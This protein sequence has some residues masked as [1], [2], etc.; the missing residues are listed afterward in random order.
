[1]LAGLA[2]IGRDT[3]QA[4]RMMLR[5]PTLAAV[6]ILS[7]GVGIGV[8]T[9]VFAWIQGRLLQPLP[10][11]RKSANL[12]L[13][14]PRS[15]NGGYPGS[16]WPEYRDLEK[17]LEAFADLIAF[18][19][20][21]LY[22]GKA[23]NVE[24]VFG[25]LVSANYFSGLG[26]QPALGRFMD[27]D[28]ERDSVAV[29]S[30]GLWQTRF[31]GSPD[32]I[33]RTIRAN[34]Q[35]LAIIG[36]A[37]REFQGTVLGLSFDVW[38][39]ATV[40]PVLTPGT[41]ELEERGA[42]G[43]ALMGRLTAGVSRGQAQAEID[44]AARELAHAYP[45]T[46]AGFTAEVLPFS[47][48]PR[49]PQR[50]LVTALLIM[51]G[52]ML[53]L[54][55]AVCGNTANLMLAR[56]S[57]RQREV[58]V[59]L[60][61]GA[62]PWRIASLLLTE[63]VVLAVIGAGL[64]AVIAIWGTD[65]LVTLPLSGLPIRFQT[66]VDALG[67]SF[68]IGLGLLSGLIAGAIPAMH[69]ARLD[70]Q[71]AIRSGSKTAGRSGLRHALMGTQVALAV[72][73]LIVAGLFIQSLLETRDV[74]PGFRR[75]GVMLGAYDLSGRNAGPA[76][77]RAFPIRV[78]DGLRAIPAVA[79]AAI[80]S[81]VPLDIHGLPSRTFTLEGRARMDGT[82]D[83]ASAN[84]VT[85]GYFSL[86]K[87]PIRAGTDFAD[88][89][90]EALPAQA[91]VNESFVLRYVGTSEPLGRRLQSRG[92]SYVITGVVADSLSNAFGEPSTPVI[93]FSYRDNPMPLG[94]IHVRARGGSE[95]PLT[96]EIRRVIR[97]I[98]PEVPVFNVRSLTDHVE[99]NLVFRR[100]PARLFAVLGPM[101]LALAAIGIYAV[102]D[103][104]VSLRT[105][106]IGIRLAL[107]ATRNRL[108]AQFVGENLSVIALG[109][110]VGWALALVVAMAFAGDAALQPVV[111]IGVPAILLLVATLASWLPARRAASASPMV[112]LRDS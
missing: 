33:G 94:E 12:Q 38:V 102:V 42:R 86:M 7:L 28:S 30:H 72:V 96:S 91:I 10:G 15:E 1:M 110:L 60:A 62:G 25:Q 106:E 95:A 69:L 6:V 22:I 54:L 44:A 73:V 79:S 31:G 63:S 16:S 49:G 90:A 3:R 64:G 99:T 2:Q 104:T 36:V 9:I 70:P 34:A 92:R 88:L 78:L 18:R 19:I 27:A 85:P 66:N 52:L 55:L 57:A 32:V 84:T 77:T 29:I 46:N 24:R 97:E 71:T 101:L 111:F 82:L 80:S 20:V 11:V 74:D 43:Y 61:L 65:A 76:F 56:A 23:P 5:A 75:E 35:D 93:Y 26:V 59:R 47:Q 13:I 48:S 41:R 14:E 67:L 4:L 58:G 68:A 45:Q 37:P 39:P 53:L 40:A 51:Q 87:I 109:G 105:S 83:A 50:L 17:R 100:V 107:G 89:A 112:A 81:A 103:Y 21:P 98:D 8:N 108:I